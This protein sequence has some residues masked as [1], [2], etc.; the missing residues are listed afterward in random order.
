METMSTIDGSYDAVP[1]DGPAVFVTRINSLNQPVPRGAWVRVD[2]DQ[3]DMRRAL[4]AI[5]VT[6]DN[7]TS[8]IVTDQIDIGPT[9]VDQVLDLNHIAGLLAMKGATA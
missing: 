2:Q 4:A 7:A 8:W 5:G 3:Q 9:M 6:D 1:R